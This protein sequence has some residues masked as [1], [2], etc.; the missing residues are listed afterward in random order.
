MRERR[1]KN[2]NNKTIEVVDSCWRFPSY[3][4]KKLGI[5]H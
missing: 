5:E 3:S 2:E 1:G 4:P